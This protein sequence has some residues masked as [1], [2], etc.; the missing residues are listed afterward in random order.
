MNFPNLEQLN[1]MKNNIYD[2]QV[3]ER[4]KFE[5]LYALNILGN[6]FPKELFASLIKDLK[7]RIKFVVV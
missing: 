2:I 3:F 6:N 7:T 5:K 1:F 4:V